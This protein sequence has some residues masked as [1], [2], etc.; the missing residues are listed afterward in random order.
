MDEGL[1]DDFLG[2]GGG[3]WFGKGEV[4]GEEGAAHGRGDEV[5]DA[6][7]VREGRGEDGALRCACGREV[8]VGDLLVRAV[9]VV[10]ALG[11]ADEVERDCHGEICEV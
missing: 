6:R 10:E 2:C 7:M 8:C 9:E 4:A 1:G 3:G 5:R 11:V